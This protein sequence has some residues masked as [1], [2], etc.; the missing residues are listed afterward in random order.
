[1]IVNANIVIYLFIE[2]KK[3]KVRRRKS[4]DRR[5]KDE[6][7]RRKSEERRRK[8]EDGSPKISVGSLKCAFETSVFGLRTSSKLIIHL[9]HFLILSFSHL[10]L[11]TSVFGL[12][13]SVFSPVF[14]LS[15]LP[16]FRALLH[17]GGRGDKNERSIVILSHKDHS[18]GIDSF[19]GFRSQVH[20]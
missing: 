16:H 14:P 19:Q 7:R 3:E 5:R 1:M 13:T 15:Q 20:Q 17:P 8:S 11:L 6:V 4:G 10:L 12:P 2:E 9:S 18:L